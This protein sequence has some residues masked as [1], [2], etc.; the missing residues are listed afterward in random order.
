MTQLTWGGYGERFYEVGI[1][2]GVLYIPA[3]AGVAWNGLISV[4]ENPS[5][6]EAKPYYLDG[7]KYLNIAAAEEFVATL[8]AYSHPAQFGPCDGSKSVHN[9]LFVTQQPRISFGLSYRTKV[10]SNASADHGYKIHLVYNALV[11]PSQRP[12][13]TL[14]D[15][16]DPTTLSW[17]LTT[18]PPS[19]TGYK[20]TAH[21]VI[22]TRTTS[23][24]VLAEIE[25]LLYGTEE[26]DATLPTPDEV[27]AIFAP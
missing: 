9:G 8:S 25:A 14:S 13:R 7:L 22:D 21:L 3:Q 2:R 11:A 18:K 26:D 6:G 17:N 4:S 5:G 10:G 12:Y 19:I 20:P 16:A 1:D 23:A 27:I 15:S 24:E